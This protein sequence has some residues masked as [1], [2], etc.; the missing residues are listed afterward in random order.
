MRRF[1]F[2]ALG[3]AIT[4][5]LGGQPASAAG[6]T[7]IPLDPV[8]DV[9][10]AG[11]VC[12]F[13][14]SVDSVSINETLAILSSGRVFITGASVER[15]TN[16]DSGKSVVL[17]V[18]GPVTISSAAGVDTF[19][20]GGRNLWGFHRGDLGPGQ[21]GI[22]LLTTGLAILTVSESGL[23]F[24]HDGGTTENLCETLR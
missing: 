4:L 24:T 20:A 16:L 13:A 15:V 5:A 8:H 17:N 14:V 21:P 6:P 23:T 19:V 10:A 1:L 18:S 2:I 7:R 11:I 12:P 22:L 3:V 9:Q